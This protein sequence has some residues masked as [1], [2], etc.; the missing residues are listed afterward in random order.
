M[1]SPKQYVDFMQSGRGEPDFG[2]ASPLQ[3]MVGFKGQGF[4]GMWRGASFWTS[5]QVYNDGTDDYG[6]CYLPGACGY[7]ELTVD[8]IRSVIT[9][10][11][12]LNA[13]VGAGSIWVE[14]DRI[15]HDHRTEFVG[16]MIC[17]AI[18]N[19]DNLGSTI[20]TVD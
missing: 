10:N 11:A 7:M 19:E 6:A 14:K 2:F 12:W 9:D 20:R 18:Q 1:L 5:S 3:G 8:Q 13:A 17:G 4:K 15:S 16:A